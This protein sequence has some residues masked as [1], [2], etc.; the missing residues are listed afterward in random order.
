MFLSS[1]SLCWIHDAYLETWFAEIKQDF[2]FFF[3]QIDECPFCHSSTAFL[4]GFFTNATQCKCMCCNQKPWRNQKTREQS[5]G[6]MELLL[7]EC[8]TPPRQFAT[9]TTAEYSALIGCRASINQWWCPPKKEVWVT[10][11]ECSISMLWPEHQ[12]I[13]GTVETWTIGGQTLHHSWSQQKTSS[14]SAMDVTGCPSH[15]TINTNVGL[16]SEIVCAV[17]V[18]LFKTKTCLWIIL[19]SIHKRNCYHC[20]SVPPD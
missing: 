4:P 16:S 17:S 9:R 19:L 14:V 15:F 10:Q 7:S 12:L 2:T 11:P 3:L 5:S 18:L 6:W 1:K 20:H 8:K 13:T